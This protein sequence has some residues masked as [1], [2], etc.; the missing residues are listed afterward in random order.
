[1]GLDTKDASRD[2]G[3]AIARYPGLDGIRG[4]AILFVLT[5]HFGFYPSVYSQPP[6]S[7]VTG[8][9]ARV[10]AGGWIGVDLFFVLSGFLITSILLASKGE[11]RYFQN[12]Y[13]RRAVRILPL[14][15]TALVV[16]LFVAP[17]VFGERW[18]HFLGDAWPKQVWLW[19]YS[20]NI[21]V[22]LRVMLDPGVF[23]PLWS[24]A[25]EE[26]YYLFWPFIVKFTSRRML[27]GI[28]AIFIVG[29]LV[30]RLA[31]LAAGFG[32]QGAYH[33]TLA[34][35]DPIAVG[36]A[37]AL[38]MQN[39]AWRRRLERSALPGLTLGAVALAVMY[40]RYPL[41]LPTEAI[42]V[43][44]GHSI[45]ALTFGCLVVIALRDPAPQW[46][47][48]PWLAKL[49]TYSY[50]IYVWHY[51]V[52][53]IMAVDYARYPAATPGG[54]AAV[55][56]GFLIVGVVI[57]TACGWISYIVLERPFLKLKRLFRYEPSSGRRAFA[58]PEPV[59]LASGYWSR[60]RE[61]SG[62]S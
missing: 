17:A 18:D 25:I 44:F 22:S 40:A 56:V 23:G 14:Y 29:S 6:Y 51:F 16:G 41:F 34:R 12:F 59:G 62:I 11:P 48:A 7:I 52:R 2:G 19:T 53:Q 9:M 32:W 26:Q 54:R 58:E 13:G 46:L 21:A 15:Y 3:S 31:W 24:L 33:F 42:I 49:G 1:M 4:V 8:W 39:A 27:G 38:L 35:L 43:T 55:A 20:L 36:A 37:I 61:S 45:I 60:R 10:F 47:R 5:M 50:G 57:S 28:C 30:V